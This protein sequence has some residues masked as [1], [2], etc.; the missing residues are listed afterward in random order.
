MKRV[1]F[2]RH[3]MTAFNADPVRLRG[4][5][6]VPLSPTGFSQIED[7]VINLK[8]AFPDIKQI[9]ST[10][11]ERG[12]ILATSVAHEYGLKVVKLPGLKSW[13]YGVL[14]GRLVSDV[15][16]VLKQM[17]TG[18][19]RLLAPKGG[20][21]MHD[22]MV[23]LGPGTSEQE[24][25][26]KHIIYN[27]PEEGCVLAVTHLQNIMIGTHWLSVGLPE[28]VL[29]MPYDYTETSEVGPGSWVEIRRDWIKVKHDSRSANS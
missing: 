12:S 2:L 3:P 18:A 28:D 23:A 22:F 26:I 14:N 25:A 7:I 1:I 24:G 5:L 11:L 21:S 6:D 16:D 8:K 4:G 29:N 13:D 10:E 9:Y 15:I 27:A 17:S 19:G 20:I